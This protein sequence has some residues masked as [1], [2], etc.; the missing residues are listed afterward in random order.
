MPF[1]RCTARARTD[2][3]AVLSQAAEVR[4]GQCQE[5]SGSN[6]A[7]AEELV[8]LG[9]R[10]YANLRCVDRCVSRGPNERLLLV[11]ITAEETDR[12]AGVLETALRELARG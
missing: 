10:P 8:R 9:L 3:F 1:E 4:L 6:F 12:A 2:F 11:N 7:R 5:A